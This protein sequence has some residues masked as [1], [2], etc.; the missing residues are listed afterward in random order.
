MNRTTRGLLCICLMGVL[1]APSTASAATRGFE[2]TVQGGGELSFETKVKKGK[3]KQVLTPLD[4][5]TVPLSC[6]EGNGLLDLQITGD[7]LKVKNRSFRL[8]PQDQPGG[9]TFTFRGKFNKK[10]KKAT[11]TYRAQGDFSFGAVIGHNCDT[12]TVE[13]SARKT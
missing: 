11:G 3:T 6:T 13:W 5:T 9:Q 10:G 8:T 1:V 12:G 7:P 2:G 4:I